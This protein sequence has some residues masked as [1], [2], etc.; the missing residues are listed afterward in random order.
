MSEGEGYSRGRYVSLEERKSELEAEKERI[1]QQLRALREEAHEQALREASERLY[2]IFTEHVE[3][4]EEVEKQLA[5]VVQQS[6][7]LASRIAGGAETMG[8][9]ELLELQ[10]ELAQLTQQRLELSKKRTSL[11]GELSRFVEEEK[12]MVPGSV[13]VEHRESE[14]RI[15]SESVGSSL[16][17]A[18][19]DAQVEPPMIQE[20][21]IVDSWGEAAQAVERETP[22]Q[23]LGGWADVYFEMYKDKYPA[24]KRGEILMALVDLWRSMNEKQRKEFTLPIYVPEGMTIEDAWST[25]KGAKNI[26]YQIRDEISSDYRKGKISD[27]R[28]RDGNKEDTGSVVSFARL[29]SADDGIKET[30]DRPDNMSPRERMVAGEAYR[31]FTGGQQMDTAGSTFFP[32]HIVV[33][34]S[35][36]KRSFLEIRYRRA[37]LAHEG[38]Y[39]PEDSVELSVAI[40]DQYENLSPTSISGVRRV[41]RPHTV[42]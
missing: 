39:V 2:T 3:D 19:D 24:L 42:I 5:G 29:S 13:P 37:Q 1:E 33:S 36:G 25:V 8:A 28:R 14:Q 11:E 32:S 18:P 10:N 6:K 4:I 17:Q 21:D 15:Q 27:I 12:K 35:S 38:P 23:E 34:A 26:S 22:E 20:G 30:E 16:E 31:R 41:V 40:S 7:E 9:E